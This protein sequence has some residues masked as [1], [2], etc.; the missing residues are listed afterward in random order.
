MFSYR[1]SVASSCSAA[2]YE[3]AVSELYSVLDSWTRLV[4]D[5]LGCVLLLLFY[6][7]HNYTT[8]VACSTV[9]GEGKLYETVEGRRVGREKKVSTVGTSHT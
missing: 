3:R 9:G 5:D 8:C 1:H 6:L 7:Y 2:Y 4:F